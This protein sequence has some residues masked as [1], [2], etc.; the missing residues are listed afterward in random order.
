MIGNPHRRYAYTHHEKTI[1]PDI[2]T[3]SHLFRLTL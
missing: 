2:L 3:Y 1:D